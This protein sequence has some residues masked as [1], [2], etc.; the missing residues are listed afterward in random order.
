MM[1]GHSVSKVVIWPASQCNHSPMVYELGFIDIEDVQAPAL[2]QCIQTIGD[3]C[4][5]FYPM[6]AKRNEI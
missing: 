2:S 6:V 1:G 4:R 3:V 5:A